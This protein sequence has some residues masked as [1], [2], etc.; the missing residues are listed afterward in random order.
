MTD[1]MYSF[2][3]RAVNKAG[4]GPESEEMT[5]STNGQFNVMMM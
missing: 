2:T 5:F 1:Q 3:V 4:I